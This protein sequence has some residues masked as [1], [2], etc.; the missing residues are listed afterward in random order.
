MHVNAATSLKFHAYKAFDGEFG[1]AHREAYIAPH[2]E[3][4]ARRGGPWT[5]GPEAA[6][7][8]GPS[9]DALLLL[10]TLGTHAIM[11]R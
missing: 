3:R 5:P 1:Q 11:N 7:E 6:V 8:V 2:S 10:P 9:D 4:C